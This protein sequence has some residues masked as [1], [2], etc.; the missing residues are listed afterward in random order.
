MNAMDS[1]LGKILGIILG[2]LGLL[3]LLAD[4]LIIT[5]IHEITNYIGE[6]AGISD[7]ATLGLTILSCIIIGGT[8]LS[9]FIIAVILFYI[10]YA[11]IT[12]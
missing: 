8:L 5:L 3:F 4:Y 6:L 12:S 7:S 10:G 1:V 9:L 2:L 11:V